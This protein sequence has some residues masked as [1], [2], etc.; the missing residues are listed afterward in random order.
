[1][2]LGYKMKGMAFNIRVSAKIEYFLTH[3]M[4]TAVT[5]RTP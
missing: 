1:M 4:L 3:S 2:A 5:E